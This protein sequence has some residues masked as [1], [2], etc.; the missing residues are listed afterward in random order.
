[1]DYT[2]G[3]LRTM[4][5]IR[6]PKRNLACIHLRRICQLIKA[7]DGSSNSYIDSYL[8]CNNIMPHRISNRKICRNCINY[9]PIEKNEKNN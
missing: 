5:A 1:M 7:T 6:P 8:Q 2:K 4:Q 3:Q 9:K